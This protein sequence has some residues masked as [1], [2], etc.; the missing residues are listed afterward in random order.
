[1]VAALHW[2]EYAGETIHLGRKSMYSV[3]LRGKLKIF[4][5]CNIFNSTFTVFLCNTMLVDNKLHHLALSKIVGKVPSMYDTGLQHGQPVTYLWESQCPIFKERMTKRLTVMPTGVGRPSSQVPM[6]CSHCSYP[7]Q[8]FLMNVDTGWP[9]T[10]ESSLDV[11]NQLQFLNVYWL[12]L[13]CLESL[14]SIFGSESGL[15]IQNPMTV[16][17]GQGHWVPGH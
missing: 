11:L 1:L 4:L 16:I 14:D 2:V 7:K 3:L 12:V 9:V 5:V 13:A 17:G 10:C 8:T 15:Q 6:N